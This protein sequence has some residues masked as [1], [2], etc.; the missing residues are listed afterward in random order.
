MSKYTTNETLFRKYCSDYYNQKWLIHMHAL[1]KMYV[2]SV[3][4]DKDVCVASRIFL[5]T[6]SHIINIISEILNV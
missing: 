1:T 6:I 4:S 5:Q 3:E 2:L